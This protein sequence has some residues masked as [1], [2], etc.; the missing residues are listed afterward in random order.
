[1]RFMPGVKYFVIAWGLILIMAPFVPAYADV[2]LILDVE[3]RGVYEDNVV[4]I[5]S[6][7]QKAS[8][9]SGGARA[10]SSVTGAGQQGPGKS[11]NASPYLGSSTQNNDD[12]VLEVVADLG[13]TATMTPDTA[14]FI[15]GSVENATYSR[16]SDF[17]STIAGLN[18]GF[19]AGL[20]PIFLVKFLA[21]VRMKEFGDS[22]RDGSAY[23]GMVEL[24]Q[25]FTPWLDLKEAYEYEKNHA[26]ATFFSYTGHAAKAGIGFRLS[27]SW[28]LNLGYT[29]LLREYEE[30]A[31]FA[32]TSHAI[33]AGIRKTFFKNWHLT[34]GYAREMSSENLNN[35]RS[36]NNSYSIG[37]LFTH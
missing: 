11:S 12:Y 21:F 17:N 1:M 27:E 22:Q 10:A 31:D 33:S 29:Y 7:Q 2:G 30:P 37:V 13:I 34:A 18:T 35:T 3:L 32:V 23:G 20:G 25:R 24:K 8:Q 14:L 9:P 19:A 36:T 26:D 6:D 28:M 15:I 5:L 4:G 16:Y